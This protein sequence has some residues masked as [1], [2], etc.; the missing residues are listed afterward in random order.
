M[1]CDPALVVSLNV[2]DVA[3]TET[4]PPAGGRGQ[5]LPFGGSFFGRSLL[6]GS[7]LLR[8]AV[9]DFVMTSTGA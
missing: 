1:L 8:D 3:A 7:V 6:D 2:E 5:L 4:R 9:F